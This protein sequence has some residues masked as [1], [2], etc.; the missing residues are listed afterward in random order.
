VSR[1]GTGFV[2]DAGEERLAEDRRVTDDYGCGDNQFFVEVT[3]NRV[4]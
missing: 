1:G 4:L 3:W 2:G